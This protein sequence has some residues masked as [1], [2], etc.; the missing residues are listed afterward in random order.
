MARSWSAGG[1]SAAGWANR[2]VMGTTLLRLHLHCQVLCE[3]KATGIPRAGTTPG[4]RLRVCDVHFGRCDYRSVAG[5]PHS[6]SIDSGLDWRTVARVDRVDQFLPIGTETALQNAD[7]AIPA[8]DRIVVSVR[9]N[10]F[11]LLE[12]GEC[13]FEERGHGVRRTAGPELRF[14]QPFP[15]QT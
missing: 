12:A 7:A 6:D 15:Q 8:Q 11:R 1:C 9:A 2:T 13:F 3:A 10:L 14:R 4:Y 5:L